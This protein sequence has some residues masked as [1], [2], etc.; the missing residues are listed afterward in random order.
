MMSITG[1][2]ISSLANHARFV[3]VSAKTAAAT[4]ITFL[5]LALL[6][7][8]MIPC[9]HCAVNII[10]NVIHWASSPSQNVMRWTS[11]RSSVV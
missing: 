8:F 11:A 6:G 2:S 3:I 9:G 1:S 7:V 10:E 4:Q 5:L